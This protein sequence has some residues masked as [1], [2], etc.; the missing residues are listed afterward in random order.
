MLGT[1]DPQT[2]LL[3]AEAYC[4]HL[5]AEESIHRKLAQ[6]GDALFADED[7]ADL[8]DAARG[9]HSVPPSM[10]AK[11]LL[12][13]SLEGTSDR[14][15][16]DRV[17]RDIGWKVALHLPL[18]DE[19]FHPTVLVYFRERL[20][21]SE[22]PRRIFERFKE[23]ATEA[24]LLTRRGTRVLDSTPVLSAVQTQDTVSLIRGAVRRLLGLLAK[25]DPNA[26]QAVEGALAR[27]DYD[28]VGKPPID[29]DDAAARE[30]LV[31]ELVRDAEGALAV[32]EGAE[33]PAPV[34]DAAE[35]LAT[36]AGQ[37][38]EA[39]DD[40]RFRIR[41]G[42]ARDRVIS[43]VD[44]EARHGRKSVHGHF[45]GYKA[46]VAVEPE[47][48]LITEVQVTPAN[49]ADAEPVPDLL[50]ELGE[51][52]PEE[53]LQVVGDTAYGTG[54]TRQAMA[55]AGAE[56][57]AKAP[58]TSNSHGG[59]P[60]EAFTIDLVRGSATCPAGIET[61]R[62][63][64]RRTT[65]EVQ[66]RFPAEVCAACPLRAQCTSSPRGRK[67]TIG[68]YEQLLAEAR[69]RQRTQKFKQV[70]NAKRPTVERVISRLVRRGGRKARYRGRDKIAAQVTL[71]AAS[72]N[73]LR[74][75]RL[76][77]SWAPERSWVTA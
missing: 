14:E 59:F 4:G 71:K 56:L 33:L 9:R 35:L 58:P 67:V 52:D 69:A 15:T 54:P 28:D 65:G 32:L 13:Q 5:V 45:N 62:K 60:K 66:F 11:V 48:E 26:K 43:L 46:H 47:T 17:R 40:G 41:R 51:Q 20:R 75:L 3:D 31:D 73:L 23:V 68:R 77:L 70:Y 57:V 53:P 25:S 50:P 55:Q 29:W 1:L 64:H 49:T 18:Q 16:V 30:A 63:W 7:F 61:T 39:T 22:R 36:V 76:G 37:D 34:A 21:R 8:Y 74:L 12:L 38:V 19:G 10:L 2:E 42:V 72:E 24:G 27:D 44:P 6:V